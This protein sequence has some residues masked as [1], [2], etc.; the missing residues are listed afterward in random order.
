MSTSLIFQYILILLIVALACY[1][2]FRMI[3][4]N[5][6]PKKFSSKRTHC[7]KDCGCS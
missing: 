2:L 4:K 6:A 3:R 7:D 1:S 5:F